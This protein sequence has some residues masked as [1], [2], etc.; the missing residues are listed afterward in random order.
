MKRSIL[1][2]AGIIAATLHPATARPVL[3][4][5]LTDTVGCTAREDVLELIK[6]GHSETTGEAFSAAARDRVLSAVRN[7]VAEGR[8]FMIKAGQV[9]IT[10]LEWQQGGE[11][12]EGAA[13]LVTRAG[14]RFYAAHW[15]WR[16][17]GDVQQPPR[18]VGE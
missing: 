4:M 8:C 16:Y 9:A 5:A 18:F 12:L 6:A 10:D 3:D 2:A 14:R 13:L 11:L 7:K 15:A 1:I 17:V